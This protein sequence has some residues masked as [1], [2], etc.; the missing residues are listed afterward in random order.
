MRNPVDAR[1]QVEVE[2]LALQIV[3]EI[4]L[5]LAGIDRG[6]D[7][8][9]QGPILPVRAASIQTGRDQDSGRTTAIASRFRAASRAPGMTLARFERGFSG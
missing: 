2:S 1:I 5:G 9:F 3:I 4:I 7:G 8:F 6:F